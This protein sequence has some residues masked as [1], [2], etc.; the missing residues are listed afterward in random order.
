MLN[1]ATKRRYND[2]HHPQYREMTAINRLL[3]GASVFRYVLNLFAVHR[4]ERSRW[5]G[6][7]SQTTRYREWIARR[8]STQ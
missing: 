8:D 6:R 2:T 5:S 3:V 1:R 4:A 7:V